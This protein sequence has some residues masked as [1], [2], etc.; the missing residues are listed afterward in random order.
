[1]SS[2]GF[3]FANPTYTADNFF[4]Y[5]AGDIEADSSI[6]EL[7][8]TEP[9][10]A[11]QVDPPVMDLSAVLPAAAI[12]QIEAAG[13]LVFH[14]IGDT[15]GIV[16]PD[17]QLA[18]ADA[19]CA[20]LA[21]KTYA[22]GEPAFFYHLGDVVYYF[23]QQQY[24]PEQF[25]DPYRNYDAP[26]FAIPGNHDGVMYSQEPVSYSLQPF[27][28]NFCT[29]SPVAAVPSFARTTMTQPGC[30][31]V[32]TAPFAR[33]IGLYSNTGEEMGVVEDDSTVG[34]DQI[35]FLEQQ[36]AA[37][38]AARNA[39]NA[40]PEA[41]ILAVH[42]PPFTGSSQHFPSAAML[43]DIDS[44]CEQAGIWPDLVLSGHSHLYERYTRIMASDGRQ[45]AYVVAGNGGYYN[46]STMKMNV[47]GVKPQPGQHSEPDG[48]GNTVNLDQYNETDFGFLRITVSASEIIVVSLGVDPNAAAGTA[49]TVI[50]SFVVN[51]AAHTV[52]TGSAT[53]ATVTRPVKKK[54]PNRGSNSGSSASGKSQTPV[55]HRGKSQSS[56]THTKSARAGASHAGSAKSAAK[57]GKA[58]TSKRRS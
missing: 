11:P 52:A 43:A 14:S 45:I 9:I 18:V 34:Q 5:S 22:T 38:L 32:L 41:L 47:A 56:G 49:P 35:T 57:A 6:Q 54:L 15:G 58:K 42:H 25:Y 46:L 51:L 39:A 21:N 29:A 48:Q 20:D 31:F 53:A 12:A 16:K 1:M 26:I 4:T 23:G 3:A 50:D 44:C 55:T 13:Q 37:A 27:V 10:P 28:E 7:Q 17:A 30:Y 24:Y 2:N 33:F 19:M 8:Q 40:A 36:L